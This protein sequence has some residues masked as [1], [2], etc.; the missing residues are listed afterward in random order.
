LVVE[1]IGEHMADVSPRKLS[2]FPTAGC[3]VN[4]APCEIDCCT[5]VRRPSP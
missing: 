1:L 3:T 4:G 5:P 2:T